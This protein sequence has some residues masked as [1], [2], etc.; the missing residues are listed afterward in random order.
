MNNRLTIIHIGQFKLNFSNGVQASMFELA[1]GQ[2]KFGH[3]VS[4]W[5]FGRKPRPDEIEEADKK[6]IKLWGIEANLFSSLRELRTKLK[7]KSVDFVHFHS[8]FIPV[9]TFLGNYLSRRGINYTVKPSGNLGALELKR[10]SFKKFIYSNLF[11]KQF[12]KK[13]RMVWCINEAEKDDL[14]A[15]MGKT[16]SVVVPNPVE[17]PPFSKLGESNENNVLT[18]KINAVFLGKSDVYHKGLDFLL[19]ISEIVNWSLKLYVI[20]YKN[21]LV[22]EFSDLVE[23]ANASNFNVHDPV[24]GDKKLQVFFN[25]DV[26]VHL[27][28][29]EVFGRTIIEAMACSLPVILSENC[30]LAPEVQRNN[31]GLVVPLNESSAVPHIQKYLSDRKKLKDDGKRARIWAEKRFSTEAVARLSIEAYHKNI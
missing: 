20:P 12:L 15:F 1:C 21:H 2:A 16:K 27:A 17:F 22:K 30:Y 19:K 13:A 8:V 23:N 10:K 11:E 5:S 7:G 18:D 29:W 26:Y 28:R 31:I 25:A 9:H 3:D 14:K 4:I 24:Y 6:N